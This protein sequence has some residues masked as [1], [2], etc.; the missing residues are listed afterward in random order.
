MRSE[1]V[2]AEGLGQVTWSLR[3]DSPL[4]KRDLIER[5]GIGRTAVDARLNE[6]KR[7]N[8]ITEA[9][10]AES[11][12]GRAPRSI[13]LNHDA[14]RVLVAELNSESLVAGIADLS[15]RVLHWEEREVD[16]LA[17]P[18]QP[19]RIVT[20]I[21]EDLRA[22]ETKN[23]FDTWAIGMGVLGPVDRER[24]RP[25]PLAE[26]MRAWADYPVSESL[27]A[28][29]DIPAWIENEANVMALGEHRTGLLRGHDQAMLVKVSKG[30]G[31][32]ILVGGALMPGAG[33]AAGEIG[34]ITVP[35]AGDRRCWCGNVGC[36]FT[37]AGELS[38]EEDAN[39]IA[40]RGESEYLAGERMKGTRLKAAVIGRGASR[41]DTPCVELLERA[42]AAVGHAIA[43]SVNV[44]NPSIVVVTGTVPDGSGIVLSS[45]QRELYAHALSVVATN[46]PVI[47]RRP[48]DTTGLVGA[49]HLAI[50]NLLSEH[51]LS[52]WLDRGTPVGSQA[53]LQ[54]RVHEDARAA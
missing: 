3:R 7:A 38:L 8:L 39:E 4:T 10:L 24:G 40:R 52:Q 11:T 36:L 32:G 27:S 6:L 28:A 2:P 50:D 49:A 46:L 53:S 23:G 43:A 14:G 25:V 26:L 12:G 48:D 9:G 17:G 45:A 35:Q 37:V 54:P 44:L 16:V 15:G 1:G 5:V 41:G 30:I 20:E 42:G 18:E 34:H 29:F 31:A 13:S 21:F 22:K 19:M 47:F 51:S 33:G